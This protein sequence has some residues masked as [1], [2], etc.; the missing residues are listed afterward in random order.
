VSGA[1]NL[2]LLYQEAPTCKCKGGWGGIGCEVVV[3][4]L[5]LDKPTRL[6]PVYNAD[7]KLV[8]NSAINT[9]W[10]LY[11]LQVCA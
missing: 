2:D 10:S 11:R 7:M 4:S 9:N 6:V 3:P 1:F 8:W 5:P